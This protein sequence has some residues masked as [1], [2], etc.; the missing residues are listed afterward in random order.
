MINTLKVVSFNCQNVKS[1]V[2][3]VIE[4]CK[5]NDII[6][7]Q[8][9]WL[10]NFDLCMLGQISNEF[11]AKG[12]SAM[13]TAKG[14]INGRPHGG[15]ACLW[16]KSLGSKCKTM[17]YDNED[18]IMGLELNVET[19]KV[20]FLNVY[21]PF[22][23]SDNFDEFNV[24]INKI[25]NLICTADTPL[26]YAIGDFNADIIKNQAFGIE[27]AKFCQEEGLLISDHMRLSH[28]TYTYYS[29][30]HCTT[31]WL[32]HIICTNSAHS[33][34]KNV[35]VYYDYVTS[36]H[37]PL[38]LEIFQYQNLFYNCP[39]IDNFQSN[40]NVQWDKLNSD[41]LLCYKY[42]T[43][44]NVK[45]ICIQPDVLE[46]CN[47]TCT[48]SDHLLAIDNL[49]DDII[50]AL[51]NSSKTLINS[52]NKSC[53]SEMNVPGWNDLCKDTHSKARDAFLMWRN[54]GSPKFG[55][56]FDLM[57]RTRALFKLTLRECKLNKKHIIA[58]SLAKK[59]LLKD[60]KSFWSVIQKECNNKTNVGANTINGVS[61]KEN[62]CN[63]WYKHYNKLLNTCKDFSAKGSVIKSIDEGCKKE[64]F[65]S[66]Y[67]SP[68]DVEYAISNMKNG[69][70]NGVDGLTSE[71][72]KYSDGLINEFFCKF[73]NLAIIHG[74]IPKKALETVLVPI[75][76]DKKGN[77]TDVDNYRPIAIATVA[78]KIIEVLLLNKYESFF[79]TNCNQFGF[80][81]SHSTDMCIF[82]LKEV[83]DFY[84]T[85][86]SPV[87]MCFMDASKAFD[88]VNHWHLFSKLIRRGLPF[89]VIRFL[90]IWYS[91]Q[92]FIVR[93]CDAM[94]QPFYVTNGVRQGG[95]L[96]PYLYNVFID[97]LS[98]ELNK[99]KLGCKVNN[100]LINHLCYADDSVLL[101]PS[102]AALQKLLNVC[103]NYAKVNE[104]TY[105]ANKTK[106]MCVKPKCLKK[107]CV[108]NVKLNDIVLQWTDKQKYL[109]VF[110]MSDNTDG[111][112]LN[113][114]LRAIYAKGNLL[115]RKFQHCT[116]DVKINL[117]K[118]YFSNF[119]CDQ[120]W[121]NFKLIELQK[122]KT[123]FNNIFRFLMK[124]PKG[125]VLSITNKFVSCNIDSFDIVLRKSIVNLRERL[126]CSNNS[127]V[128]S[129]VNSQ[130]F[131]LS[132]RLHSR[133]KRYIF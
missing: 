84:N 26:V 94:S 115:L 58:D 114:Q 79:A 121:C 72:F 59:Y 100:C 86:S 129:L 3:E 130:F 19:G 17:I 68:S 104:I 76:K 42:Y 65:S 5:R 43:K 96:S 29:N 20:L 97:D 4:L 87:Y 31:S 21:M 78:S 9:T 38:S 105:N 12:I 106:C 103:D 34:I 116:V 122:V 57:K 102:P 37:V 99:T 125:I 50:N 82:L 98:Y 11:Y 64:S 73:I 51:V 120:L 93:W 112:D 63:L 88:R 14:I 124:M 39:Q 25:N 2:T 107:L 7:L 101:A 60:R 70:C 44:T 108:P 91:T 66:S 113:R 18:R 24:Y 36:D 32:D 117:F 77:I 46:C 128:N 6:F 126:M 48:N 81:P 45:S 52:C 71:H 118:T 53:S 41:E 49:Y 119:Y 47:N 28:D 54:N 33:L 8:E 131:T 30:A 80:K 15:L 27:L 95:V 40:C 110:L 13:D 23:K 111:E 89:I 83:I 22:C 92:V 55:P 1:S 90:C 123:A 62:I 75:V 10:M 35:S 74:Y 127:L 67:F 133:W 69:K 61:G 16:R 132:S 56:I 85:H 109:G